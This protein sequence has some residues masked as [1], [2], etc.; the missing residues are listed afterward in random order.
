[1]GKEADRRAL[2]LS[3]EMRSRGL[4]VELGY[5]GASLKSQMRRADRLSASFALIVGDEELASGRL[6]W[7]DLKAG[8]SGEVPFGEAAG[9]IKNSLK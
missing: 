8:S 6:K 7:R 9:F 5:G 2:L 4:W 3:G 1:M